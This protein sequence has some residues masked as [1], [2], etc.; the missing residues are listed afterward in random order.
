V[1]TVRN[2]HNVIT[3]NNLRRFP[4]SMSLETRK[5]RLLMH[6]RDCLLEDDSLKWL[7]EIDA[8]CDVLH[9]NTGGMREW[10]VTKD[11]ELYWW[12]SY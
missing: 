11:G 7:A 8:I 6:L 2:L 3:M 10:T 9:E 1:G 12:G 5:H 4:K